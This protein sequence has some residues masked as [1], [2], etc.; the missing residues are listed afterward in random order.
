[1][2]EQTYRPSTVTLAVHA[3]RGLMT[4]MLQAQVENN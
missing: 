4:L 1:M 2:P 3:R